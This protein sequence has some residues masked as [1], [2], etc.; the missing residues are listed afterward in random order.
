MIR[1]GINGFGRIGRSI[2]RINL[3]NQ[4]YKIVA[5][6]D[7]DP[8][9]NNLAYLIEYD[10]TYGNIEQSVSVSG[11]FLNIGKEKIEIF[12]Q[13]KISDVD[14]N[15]Q[16]VD[17][18]I[19]SSGIFDNVIDARKII[20]NVKKVI[21][22]H[23]PKAG[24]DFTLM[25]GVNEAEY[26]FNKHDIISSSICDANAVA[27]FYKII[28]ENFGV[29]RGF[30]TTLHPWLS[31]QNLLDGNLKSISSPGH[32][33]QDY[34]L[35]RSSINSMIPK[36]TSLMK[37]MSDVFDKKIE[38]KISAMSFRTPTSIVSIADGT[39]LLNKKTTK[40]ELVKLMSD[41]KNSY[42]K[43]IS[44]NQKPLISVDYMKTEVASNIDLRW[45]NVNEDLLKFIIWYDNEWGYSSVTYNL[46]NIIM[47]GSN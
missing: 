24:I 31:Y 35:G 1:I 22:T 20:G 42:P 45:L 13:K 25:N 38:A 33:W 8:D 27:P 47:N 44:I 19:D 3:K 34:G 23:S 46:V 18:V 21:V 39:F 12:N 4:L 37:A 16:D 28:E 15:K 26:D 36:E 30:I 29:K 32:Y 14:W 17:V 11:N 6:N 43:T 41:F 7:I 10:S 2:L 5:I 9:I 40:E